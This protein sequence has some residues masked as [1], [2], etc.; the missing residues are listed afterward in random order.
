MES[1]GLLLVRLSKRINEAKVALLVIALLFAW[2]TWLV[3]SLAFRLD[4]METRA[5]TA[6]ARVIELKQTVKW[7]EVLEQILPELAKDELNV[8]SEQLRQ[9]KGG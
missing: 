6:E 3:G 1:T 2:L 7:A 4:N 8:L 5:L 9:K